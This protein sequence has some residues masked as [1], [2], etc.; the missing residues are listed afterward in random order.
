MEGDFGGSSP[1][2]SSLPW[3]ERR[4]ETVDTIPQTEM[5]NSAKAAGGAR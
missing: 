5:G 1:G 4:K 2:R 3:N